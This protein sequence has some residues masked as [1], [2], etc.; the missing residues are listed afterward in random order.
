MTERIQVYCDGG[1][2]G[3]QNKENIGAWAY[4]MRYKD[5]TLQHGEV[6]LNTTNNIQ[7]LKAV[8]EALKAIK[9]DHIPI[10]IHVDSAYVHN[11]ITGWIDGWKKKGWRSS[12][13][14]PV[15]NVELWKELDYLVNKQQDLRW[16][17]VRGHSDNEGNNLVDAMV[18]DI[19][20]QFVANAKQGV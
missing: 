14:K 9:T 12:T 16:Q 15:K 4:M 13:N 5:R 11:G 8:I 1:C 2:R 20:D 19:M 10:D 18:N 3:N 17:K 7:E 6:D